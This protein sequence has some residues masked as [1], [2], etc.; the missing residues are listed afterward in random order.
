MVFSHRKRFVS[1]DVSQIF[2]SFTLC[3]HNFMSLFSVVNFGSEIPSMDLR[4]LLISLL[5]LDFKPNSLPFISFS[6][7]FMFYLDRKRL[8]AAT[9]MYPSIDFRRA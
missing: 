6:G 1:S 3:N 4:K 9:V 5:T 8:I 7:R 2:V